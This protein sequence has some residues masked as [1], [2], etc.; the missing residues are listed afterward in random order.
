MQQ[1]HLLFAPVVKLQWEYL[2]SVLAYVDGEYPDHLLLVVVIKLREQGD[3]VHC[4][5]VEVGL[6]LVDDGEQPFGQ[7]RIVFVIQVGMVGFKYEVGLH[8]LILGI[9]ESVNIIHHL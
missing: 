3:G 8:H 1:P 6:G 7:L 9:H 4:H 2:L 5:L